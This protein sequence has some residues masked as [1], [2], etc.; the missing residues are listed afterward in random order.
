MLAVILCHAGVSRAGGGFSGVDVFFVLSGY[1][2]TRLIAAQQQSGT[3]SFPRFWHRRARRLLP[4]LLVVVVTTLALGRALLYPTLWP[5]LGWQSLAALTM[6]ANL[7]MARLEGDYWGQQAAQA[8]LLHTWSLSVEEQ[9]YLLFPALLLVLLRRGTVTAWRVLAIG[10]TASWLLS[11]FATPVAPSVAYYGLPTRAWELGLGACL[12]LRPPRPSRWLAL[13]GLVL[14]VTACRTVPRN[15][16]PGWWASWPVVG[17]ALLISCTGAP[18]CFTTRVLSLA[19]LQWLGRRSYSLYLWH[20]P[21]LLLTRAACLRFYHQPVA[22]LW[23]G[24]L[25]LGT[26]GALLCY[27]IVEQPLRRSAG[28]GI[29]L[30]ALLLSCGLAGVSIATPGTPESLKFQLTISMDRYDT[31]PRAMHRDLLPG[32]DAPPRAPQDA[33]AYLHDGIVHRYGGPEPQVVLLGSSHALMW[34][35]ALDDVCRELHLTVSLF[36]ANADNPFVEL[37]VKELFASTRMTAHEKFL[38]DSNRLRLLTRVR[39]AVVVLVH[40]WSVVADAAEVRPLL[41]F[42]RPLGCRVLMLE[43]PPELELIDAEVRA[44]LSEQSNDPHPPPLGLLKGTRRPDWQRGQQLIRTLAQEFPF[45]EVVPVEDLFW[46]DAYN[47]LVRDGRDIL[48]Y[49]DDHVSDAGA[50]RV[51]ERLRAYLRRALR[52]AGKS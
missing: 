24:G 9:F 12:A 10:T 25:L 46:M 13:L 21:T 34:A 38:Y 11:G 40:R 47:V 27:E 48:Y 28:V 14:V 32:L 52:A 4:A 17:S 51:R 16:F 26:L 1:L 35:S 42:I 44:T 5:A 43:A 23:K 19:P 29:L 49:D 20:W 2:I 36:A 22:W 39:P 33:Q 7:Y 15:G 6:S 45:C 30:S 31:T 37:P 3:W 41:E 8:P 50:A 18:G